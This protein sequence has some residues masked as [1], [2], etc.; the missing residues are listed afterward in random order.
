MTDK[1]GVSDPILAPI[2]GRVPS[3][4]K[5]SS[6]ATLSLVSKAFPKPAN[7][8]RI[9]AEKIDHRP[10]SLRPNDVL[11]ALELRRRRRLAKLKKKRKPT[12]LS[13]KEK[14][15][16]RIYDIPKSEVRSDLVHLRVVVIRQL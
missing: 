12:P 11:T 8:E 7:S 13:A 2:T 3:S 5:S 10:L 9:Y 16:L 14:R 6:A 1:S 15:E 4:L